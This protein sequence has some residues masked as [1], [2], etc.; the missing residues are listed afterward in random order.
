[1]QAWKPGYATKNPF[2][3]AG[4]VIPPPFIISLIRRQRQ[5]D[6]WG[7]IVSLTNCWQVGLHLQNDFVKIVFCFAVVA[8]ELPVLMSLLTTVGL[9]FTTHWLFSWPCHKPAS[10]CLPHAFML[11]QTPLSSELRISSISATEVQDIMHRLQWL[12]N[13]A[14]TWLPLKILQLLF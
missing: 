4:I 10:S 3:K 14:L 5:V 12:V 7:S 1:M 8:N 13:G 11:D 6:T 9:D 2:F